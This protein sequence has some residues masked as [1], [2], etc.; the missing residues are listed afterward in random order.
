MG[1]GKADEILYGQN[2]VGSLS[3]TRAAR[4]DPP[5]PELGR[6][7]FD[8]DAIEQVIDRGE[9]ACLDRFGV[10]GAS[11]HFSEGNAGDCVGSILAVC[12]D[13]GWLDE[14]DGFRVRCYDLGNDVGMIVVAAD[15]WRYGEGQIADHAW[16]ITEITV[17][18]AAR[19]RGE[20]IIIDVLEE[21][22]TR[23]NR[24]LPAAR[25][26]RDGLERRRQIEAVE[27]LRQSS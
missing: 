14:P 19:G 22:V 25:A 10:S 23:A 15:E 7:R 12:S 26:L 21:A 17:G 27:A 9:E 13:E 1:R 8:R 3:G 18:P 4:S 2:G 16:E 11:F 20:A 24:L 5:E 6:F